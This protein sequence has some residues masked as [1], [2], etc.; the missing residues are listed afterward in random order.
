MSIKCKFYHLILAIVIYTSCISFA[1][2]WSSAGHQIIA[3]IAYAELT[4]TT[5]QRVDELL[6]KFQPYFSTSNNFIRASSW[7]DKLR[8]TDIMAFN[9]W[10]Y[11]NKPY[12]QGKGFKVKSWESQNIVWAIRQSERVLR[13]TKASSFDKAW[14]FRFYIHLIG[15]IHQPLHCI[16]WYSPQFPRG[17]LGGNRYLI[18]SS[19]GGNLHQIWDEGLGYFKGYRGK[20][21]SEKIATQIRTAYPRDQLQHMIK[22]NTKPSAW[23]KESYQLAIRFAYQILPNH[24]V[25][26]QYLEQGKEIV[27]RQLALAGYRLA[28]QLNAIFDPPPEKYFEIS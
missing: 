4:S 19:I 22:K 20:R 18:Q 25:T 3:H 5:K 8:D 6:E 15:D 7:A 1:A 24:P 27:A 9:H 21:D 14:F 11:I 16:E 2:A 12:L 26:P 17:D 23:A 10:H 13:S 28:D